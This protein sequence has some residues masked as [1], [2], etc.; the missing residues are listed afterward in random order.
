[1]SFRFT[2]GLFIDTVTLKL[3]SLTGLSARSPF[4]G[5]MKHQAGTTPIS[6]VSPF[7]GL[8][9]DVNTPPSLPTTHQPSS[10]DCRM[11]NDSSK[12]MKSSSGRIGL[13]A[14]LTLRIERPKPPPDVVETMVS[15]TDD[16][17]EKT[18]KR[19]KRELAADFLAAAGHSLSG[20]S[21]GDG[22]VWTAGENG[23]EVLSGKR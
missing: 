15:L 3:L 16:A 21:T 1:M 5:F 8:G 23:L 6:I 14:C 13:K 18:E 17:A 11:I 12:A 10:N 22:E 9:C 20:M 4:T 2:P 7:V 19:D